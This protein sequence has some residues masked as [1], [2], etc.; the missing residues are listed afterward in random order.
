M[1]GHP[2]SAPDGEP[3]AGLL[4]PGVEFGTAAV[5][6]L[7]AALLVSVETSFLRVARSGVEA[8]ERD[9]RRGAGRLAVVIADPQR[10]SNVVTLLRVCF[11][12]LAVL[13]AAAAFVAL[14]GFNWQALALTAAVMTVVG[15]TLVGVAPRVLSQEFPEA[16]ALA[17]AVVIHPLAPVLGPPARLLAVVGQALTPTTK[18]RGDRVAPSVSEDELRHLV[19]LAE[20]RKLIDTEERQMIHSVFQLDDTPVRDVMVPRT[21]IVFIDADASITDALA[22]SLRSGY[23]RIPVAGQNVDDLVGTVYLKDTV[24][25]LRQLG[26]PAGAETRVAEIMREASY[27]PD[28]KPVDELLREMQRQHIHLAVVIDEYGGTAGLVTME[29][30]VEEI[31][32]EITDEYDDAPESAEWLPD[33]R[34]RVPGRMP[35][36]E[37][38]EQFGVDIGGV[39]VGTVSGLLAYA[40]GRVPFAGATATHAGLRLTAETPAGRRHRTAVVVVEKLRSEEDSG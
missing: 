22:L 26:E 27:V 8:L 2:L 35:V 6:C 29:D 39:D 19:D 34:A 1:T 12:V 30:I 15:Y 37:L 23:S 28:T 33:G 24:V 5:C 3:F 32:G 16:V 4:L 31:V 36:A 18:S 7:L 17:G 9:Q 38:A 10:Y 11:E 25:H 20:E 40:L 14:L 13:F 21:D